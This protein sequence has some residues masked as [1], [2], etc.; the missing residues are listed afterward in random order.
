MNSSR[1]IACISFTVDCVV[2]VRLGNGAFILCLEAL[3][4]VA[5]RSLSDDY[6]IFIMRYSSC[7]CHLPYVSLTVQSIS[8]KKTFLQNAGEAGFILTK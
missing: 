6:A 1:T 3:F 4:K 5:N 8:C 7:I 2:C